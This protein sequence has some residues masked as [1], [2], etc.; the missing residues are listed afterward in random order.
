MY[1]VMDNNVTYIFSTDISIVIF[2]NVWTE[3]IVFIHKAVTQKALVNTEF[4]HSKLQSNE[5]P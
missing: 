4:I 3:G 2:Q 5:C 1:S